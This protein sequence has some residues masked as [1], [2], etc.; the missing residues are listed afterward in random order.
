MSCAPRS[1]RSAWHST[2]GARHG[3]RGTHAH[4]HLLGMCLA[5][6]RSCN[7]PA[8]LSG[9]RLPAAGCHAPL[10]ASPRSAAPGPCRTAQVKSQHEVHRIS[11]AVIALSKALAAGQPVG[12]QLQ[13]RAAAGR[14]ARCRSRAEQPSAW[15]GLSN[16]NTRA[17]RLTHAVC[18]PCRPRAAA[19]GRLPRRP[20]CGGRRVVAAGICRLGRPADAAAAA[21]A[22]W[23]R[24]AGGG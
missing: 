10:S 7:H 12:Q 1:T 15:Q 8:A 2:R 16:P 13:V 5:L 4:V 20:C 19:G 21:A 17:Q 22:L 23:R 6:H 18:A 3:T 14:D 24:R 9:L 11:L